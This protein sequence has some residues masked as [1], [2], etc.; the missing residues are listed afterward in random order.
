[1]L[2]G[3]SAATH[4]GRQVAALVGR[5]HQCA[6]VGLAAHADGGGRWVLVLHA[7]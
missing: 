1:M 4:N 6:Q 3:R 2:V 7:F 5:R